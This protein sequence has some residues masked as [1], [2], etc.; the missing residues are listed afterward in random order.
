MTDEQIAIFRHSELEALKRAAE[1]Q[2]AKPHQIAL[3]VHNIQEDVP[4]NEDIPPASPLEGSEEGEY[5]HAGS[6]APQPS[7]SGQLKKKKKKKRKPTKNRQPAAGE[8]N[9][10]RK[11][12]QGWFKKTVKPDLRK[13]TWDVVET[14]MD[15]L[16]Y[17]E[18]D[19]VTG[20]G[21]GQVSQRRRISYDD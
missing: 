16:D 13:R 14:G 5:G 18:L 10:S 11:S 12:E 20:N 4:Q 2:G 3:D 6:D 17:D 7:N 8:S 19:A 21:L 9:E 1:K 15:S